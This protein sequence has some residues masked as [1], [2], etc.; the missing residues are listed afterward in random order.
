MKTVLDI[1]GKSQYE[2]DIDERFRPS[3]CGPVTAHVILRYHFPHHMH[4]VNEL[5]R[6]L[7]STKI[8]LFT[9]RFIRNMKKLLGEAWIV[10][11][12]SV[13]EVIHEIDNGRPVAAKFDKWFTLRW[14]GKFAFDYHWVPVVGY[15]KNGNELLL[16]VHDNGGRNRT[17]QLRTISYKKNKSILTFV[18]IKRSH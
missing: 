6:L 17:S 18:K 12:C 14:R 13:N 11:K 2:K 1:T 9:W 5:Y 7:G 8:G 10:E 16:I 15:E 3:A 4:A